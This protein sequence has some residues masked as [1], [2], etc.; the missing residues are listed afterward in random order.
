[1]TTTHIPARSAATEAVVRH[2]LQTFLEGHGVDAIVS[3]YAVDARFLTEAQVYHG[4]PEIHGFFVAF[5]AALPPGAIGRFT[6][7]SMQVDGNVAL[8][9]WSVGDAIPLG[10]DTFVVENGQIVAQTFAMHAA[11]PPHPE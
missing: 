3:D 8:I 7:R 9:T 2:H 1:M 4:K 11:P 10:T 5:V 6:L